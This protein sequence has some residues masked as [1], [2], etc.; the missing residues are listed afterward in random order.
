MQHLFSPW[1][2]QY[3]QS[4][5]EPETPP[6]A[7]STGCFFCDGYAEGSEHDRINIIV[8]RRE[9]CFVVMNRF[10]YNA[11]HIMVAPN[12]HIGQLAL[13]SDEELTNIMFTIRES[14]Q[15]LKRVFKPHAMNIGANVGREAGA[16]VPD[17]LHFH[18]VPRWNGDTNFMPVLADVRVV[19]EAMEEAWEKLSNGF[20][21]E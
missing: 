6:R 5:S 9:H 10:P 7:G 17:H 18:L 1:R 14:E 15:V 13:L 19:S 21:G 4:F 20:R 12:R 8:A 16:G 3:I 2:S 11:G